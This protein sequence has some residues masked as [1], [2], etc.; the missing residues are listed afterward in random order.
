M[1]SEAISL[2]KSNL[3]AAVSSH[4]KTLS[5]ETII[6]NSIKVA[7]RIFENELFLRGEAICIYM[8]MNEEVQTDEIINRCFDLGKRVFIPKII[9]KNSPDM[10]MFE[11]RDREQI[12][13]FPKT[14]WG[15]PEPPLQT[16]LNS[17]DGTKLGVIDTIFV[18]GVAFDPNCGRIG[19]GRGYYGKTFL[20]NHVPL[21]IFSY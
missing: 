19:H 16:A 7:Q 4:L 20:Q 11:L 14:K 2:Q 13:T 9:G 17:P 10:I 15:I 8:S 3:R 21:F 1:L 6:E 18:P 12:N 5:K